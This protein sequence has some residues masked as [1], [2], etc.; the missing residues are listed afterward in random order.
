MERDG[1]RETRLCF[2]THLGTHIDAPAHL[3][4]RGKTLDRLPLDAFT[5]KA[6]I[7]PLP[8]NAPFIERDHLTPHAGELGTVEFVLFNTGWSEYWGTSRY[9]KGFPV[10]TAAAVDHLL[11]YSLRGIGF[12][13]VSA[14]P[15]DSTGYPNHIKIL[16]REMIIIENLRFPQELD[17]TTGDFSCF[18][19]PVENADGSPVR[20]ILRVSSCTDRKEVGNG[21]RPGAGLVIP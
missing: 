11:G 3:L 20:A 2:D 1:F 7:I 8:G 18:P 12:D 6:L 16:K 10:L 9:F 4:E 17:D 5:G 13:A 19:L 15:V 14:D 21:G